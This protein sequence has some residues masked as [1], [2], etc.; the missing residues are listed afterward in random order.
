LPFVE[1][2]RA[3]LAKLVAGARVELRYGGGRSDRYGHALAQ[4]FAVDGAK[5]VRLQEVLV[6]KG[7]ARVY[8]FADN[9]ACAAELLAREQD[10]RG[11][12]RGLWRSSVYRIQDATDLERLGR[13]IHSYQLVRGRSL[14]WARGGRP[15]V[16]TSPKT[17]GATSR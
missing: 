1:E 10:A 2:A 9:R 6:G 15:F 14:R 4:V 11:K 13:L 5:C 16:S 3:A 8:S 17:G 7:L 12:R